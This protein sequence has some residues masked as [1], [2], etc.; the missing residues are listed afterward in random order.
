MKRYT[1]FMMSVLV[2]FVALAVAINIAIVNNNIEDSGKPHNI[3]INRIM[4]Q[5]QDGQDLN[6]I[7]LADYPHINN[8]EF[9]AIDAP[10]S[11]YD[12]FFNQETSLVRLLDLSA[13]AQSA[14]NVP[15]AQNVP[16]G[17]VSFSYQDDTVAVAQ[18]NLILVNAVLLVLLVFLSIVLFYIR[19][20]LIK[21]FETFSALPAKLARGQLDE[22]LQ[23]QKN[24]YFG[25]FLWGL[26][27]L[28][29]SLTQQR[30]QSLQLERERKTLSLALSHDIKTP[31]S[32]IQLYTT[33]LQN[34][35]YPDPAK[36][37]KTYASIISKTHEV[38]DYLNQMVRSSSEDF[39]AL[40]V[41][42]DEFY[43][44]DLLDSL[45]QR[46]AE[47][48][49]LLGVEL[50]VGAHS[51]SII[52]GDFERTLEA[53]ENIIE[54][55][56]K[57]GDGAPISLHFSTEEG[58]QLVTVA[59]TGNSLPESEAVHIFESFWRGSNAQS[60]SGNGLGLFIVRQIMHQMD[61]DVYATVNGE[62]IAITLVFK[63]L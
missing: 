42:N 10:Q 48:L 61:G 19:Q 55:A 32:A 49:Q 27:N 8:V 7:D 5:L 22:P 26:D 3:E 53:L 60:Q 41:Q 29:E 18:R 30:N 20:Q 59:N 23:E 40:E 25:R 39:L 1:I 62:Q 15:N 47:K 13:P 24:R 57:Y 2:L 44:N 37:Q 54:N 31:L 28:R 12:S 56:L 45:T 46:Y 35:L 43:L 11:Q 9:L 50:D 14:Q 33:A 21:P 36:Q 38:E 16:S 4:A 63:L 52:Y 34:G 58:A 51:N 17:Y 6:S